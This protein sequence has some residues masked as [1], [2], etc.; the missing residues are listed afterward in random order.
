MNRKLFF[1]SV[2]MFYSVNLA[3]QP[4]QMRGRQAF[5]QVEA[6]KIAFF[7]RFMDLTSE[8]AKDFWPVYDDFQNQRN[9]LVWERQSLSRHFAGNY[10]D[11]SAD[12]S[13]DTADRYIGLQVKESDLIREYHSK[14]KEILPPKK[15]MR[16]YQAENEF[17]TR[18][19]RRIRGGRGAG[20]GRDRIDPEF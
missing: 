7:T 5:E 18:L 14:F 11:L 16:L 17:R 9:Q 8:E 19:L 10:E 1:L 13:E 15:V 20:H 4:G 2:I 12:E 3:A 6:E